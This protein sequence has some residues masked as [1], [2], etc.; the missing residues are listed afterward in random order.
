[1]KIFDGHADIWYDVAKKR[2][3]G[4]ENIFK[5]YHLDR[6]KTGNIM[7]GIFIA[8]LEQ[9]EGQ[10]DEKEM[11]HLINSTIHEIREN[12][13]I[14]NIIREKG[15]FN[16]GI[17]EGKFDIIMGI[18][19]LKAIGKNLDWIDTF[20]ELGFRHASLTWNE[21]NHLATGVDGDKE[22]GLTSI[23]KEAV[24]KMEKLGMIIDVSHANDKTFWDIYDNTTKPIIASHSNVKALCDHKRNL[25]DEQIKA[26]AKR[27][28]VIGINAYKK[29]LARDRYKQNLER[30]V[31][32]IEH[33]ISLVGIKH[34]ALG[35][36]FCEYL[37]IDKK[38]EDINPIG[39]EN[40]SKAVSVL[41]ELYKRGYNENDIRKIAFEN[42]MRITEMIL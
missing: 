32:H 24:K 9:I 6:L 2:K 10:D 26:I 30:Y 40:A 28:G 5:K 1:M 3:L 13:D 4:E 11:F 22:R 34:A 14:F 36:D 17:V 42:F 39:L 8:Y 16:R 29:F 23:G 19:G 15:D 33:I 41:E 18:E 7:G 31:D 27:D 25:T 20:Y 21:E 35:F 12:Q 38:D 37:Y